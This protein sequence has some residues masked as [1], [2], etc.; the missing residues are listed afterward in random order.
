MKKP[1]K[2][3]WR[4]MRATVYIGTPDGGYGGSMYRHATIRLDTGAFESVEMTFQSHAMREADEDYMIASHVNAVDALPAEW[5]ALCDRSMDWAFCPFYGV[6]VER[7]DLVRFQRVG[8]ILTALHD[9]FIGASGACDLWRMICALRTLGATV[10]LPDDPDAYECGMR[11][12]RRWR[13]SASVAEVLARRATERAAELRA[14]ES[15]EAQRYT[16]AV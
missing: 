12:L 5:W 2:A 1:T 11:G 3:E 6:K 4:A 10:D 7:V 14:R 15:A 9:A 13:N 16:L 8:P